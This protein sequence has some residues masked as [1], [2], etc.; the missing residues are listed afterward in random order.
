MKFNIA[1]F[2]VGTVVET[3]VMG[4][5]PMVHE[6]N[7]WIA[8]CGGTEVPYTTRTGHVV[9]YMWNTITKVHQYYCVSQDMF[10]ENTPDAMK[11]YGI[12]F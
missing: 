8:G 5:E 9:H 11:Q 4:G 3:S 7:M 10:I 6:Q 12:W 1:Q 2:P